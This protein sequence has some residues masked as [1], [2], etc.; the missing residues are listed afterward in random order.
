MTTTRTPREVYWTG[1]VG[2]FDDFQKPITNTIIDGVT[3]MGPWAIMTP[4]THR[5][6]GQGLGTGRGQKY[7]KQADGKW[8][9]VEG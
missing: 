2:E 5:R 1:P 8:L 9:K 7:E 6:Y 4:E 3:V